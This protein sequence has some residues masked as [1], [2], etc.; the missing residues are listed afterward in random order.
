MKSITGAGVR[1]AEMLIGQATLKSAAFC[2]RLTMLLNDLRAAGYTVWLEGLSLRFDCAGDATARPDELG[3]LMTRYE[4]IVTWLPESRHELA[5]IRAVKAA[6]S[7][8]PHT[9]R[10]HPFL[11][12]RRHVKHGV[13]T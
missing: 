5:G 9:P 2:P 8:K 10:W 4:D 7:Q 13:K 6:E 12:G 3:A 1:G 11:R